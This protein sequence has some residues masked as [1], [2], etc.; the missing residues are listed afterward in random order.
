MRA[1]TFFTSVKFGLKGNRF[2]PGFLKKGKSIVS[3]NNFEEIDNLDEKEVFYEK[4]LAFDNFLSNKLSSLY[5]KKSALEKKELILDEGSLVSFQDYLFLSFFEEFFVYFRFF[6]FF[7]VKIY[8]KNLQKDLKNFFFSCFFFSKTKFFF[9]KGK[10]FT[11]RVFFDFFSLINFKLLS[12]SN[13]YYYYYLFFFNYYHLFFNC[14][15]FL[16]KER[17][18]FS[19]LFSYLRS[20]SGEI[21]FLLIIW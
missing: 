8:K 11:S 19:H 2:F 6:I 18:I 3:A 1:F 10:I 16:L 15:F 13:V 14:Y 12:F 5:E 21:L 20:L 9:F 7:F 4:L 17:Q